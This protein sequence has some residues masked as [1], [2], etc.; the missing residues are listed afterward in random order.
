MRAVITGASGLLGANLAE[1]LVQQGYTVVC[2][3]RGQTRVDHLDDLPL[4]WVEAD[5]GSTDA[6][7]RA[8]EG[9]DLVFHCAAAVTRRVRRTPAVDDANVAGSTRVLEAA[10]R[11]G[12]G[13]LVYTASTV[14]IGLAS[15]EADADESARWD[16]DTRGLADA[17]AASK[18]EG[19][20]LALAA[21]AAGQ[22]VVVVNPGFMLGP[23]DRK[24]S[25]G[26][27]LLEL[28][29]GKIPALTPGTN[30]F[31]DV[32]DVARGMVLAAQR[33]RP[34]ERYILAGHNLRYDQA[35]PMFAEWL[36][37]KPPRLRLP[38]ALSL[39]LGWLGDLGERLGER[40]P[41]LNSATVRF[42]YCGDFRFSSAK[43]E[44]ELGYRVGPLEPAVRDAMAWFKARGMA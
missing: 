19:E 6:L 1:Q 8:M 4:T 21:A 37:V 10:R 40:E 36:G 22:D 11:A 9:A 18:R 31:V 38:L 44:K 43:A 35:F 15:G 2:T 17:Y 23:R 29:R 33:G 34:G 3:R 42:G 16:L 7:A 25:S 26:T 5:L 12:V 39:P 32:R 30:S 20:Q 13:R 41:L 28:Y 27:L 24:P 14:T